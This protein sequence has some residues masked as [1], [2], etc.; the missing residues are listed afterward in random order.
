MPLQPTLSEQPTVPMQPVP[1]YQPQPQEF[2]PTAQPAQ[3][4]SKAPLFII[5]GAAVLVVALIVVLIVT[6][7]FGL[8]GKK[9]TPPPP[10]ITT[11][12]PVTT[13]TPAPTEEPFVAEPTTPTITTPSVTTPDAND[14]IIGNW[15]IVT[16]ELDGVTYNWIDIK[17]SFAAISEDLDPSDVTFVLTFSDNGT[18]TMFFLGLGGDIMWQSLGGG[19]YSITDETTDTMEMTITNN[20]LIYYDSASNSTMIFNKS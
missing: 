2:Q 18:G 1:P 6:G 10:P 17:D 19:K 4:K 7:V 14:P 9:P 11:E 8:V 12:K 15:E 20:Q 3:K 5:I 16:Y 13:E